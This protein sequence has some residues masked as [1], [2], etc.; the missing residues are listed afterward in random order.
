MPISSRQSLAC[1]LAAASRRHKISDFAKT[2]CRHA[3]INRFVGTVPD[4]IGLVPDAYIASAA[5]ITPV[6]FNPLWEMFTVLRT[7]IGLEVIETAPILDVYQ[8]PELLIP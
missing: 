4:E 3:G 2:K 7:C 5:F 8:H 6:K 1:C